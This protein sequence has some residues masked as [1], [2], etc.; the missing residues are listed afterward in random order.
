[1]I[2]NSTIKTEVHYDEKK[3]NKYL[4]IK[5]WNDKKK[6][7]LVLMKNAGSSSELILDQSTMYVINNLVRND[8]GSVQIANLFSNITGKETKASITE[9]LEMIKKAATQVTDV[10]IAPGKGIATNKIASERLKIILKMLLKEKVKILE[11]ETVNGR[12][13][14]HPLCPQ[15]KDGWSLVEYVIKDKVK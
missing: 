1:M 2:T 11:I 14:F 7:A 12:R 3:N 5:T 8:Y 6:R 15:V 13:G 10:I 9:N 4:V